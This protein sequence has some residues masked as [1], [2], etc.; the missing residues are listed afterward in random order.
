MKKND[1]IKAIIMCLIIAGLLIFTIVRII[2][3]NKTEDVPKKNDYGDINVNTNTGVIEDKKLG[4]CLG[5]AIKYIS[6]AGK[7]DPNKEVE[8]L[9]KAN[10]YINR[11]IKE[12][13]AVN[14]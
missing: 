13:E 6:R 14:D 2:N 4:F 10:W 1:K 8:D 11:R 3:R 5:N 7:K 9:K 12:L